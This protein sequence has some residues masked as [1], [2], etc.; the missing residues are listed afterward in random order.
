MASINALVQHFLQTHR[1]RDRDRERYEQLSRTPE[2]RQKGDEAL[3]SCATPFPA[4]N[5]PGLQTPPP[6]FAKNGRFGGY[7]S[8]TWSDHLRDAELWLV[9]AMEGLSMGRRDVLTGNR[10]VCLDELHNHVVCG[11]AVLAPGG[12]GCL[13]DAECVA[14]LHRRFLLVPY[15]ED[16]LWVNVVYDRR[17]GAVSTFDG[18]ELGRQERHDRAVAALQSLMELSSL[19]S[20]PLTSHQS[21]SRNMKPGS[22]QNSGYL[23]LEGARVFLREVTGAGL[24]WED[25]TTSPVYRSLGS[26]EVADM[27]ARNAWVS[28]LLEQ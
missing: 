9:A 5:D 19:P 1:D 21:E 23:A 11:R 20:I 10:F 26:D 7:G 27:D 4:A 2:S 22:K 18:V 16:G 28:M 17:S 13:A 8:T 14:L 25:W 6:A 15:A 3:P 12:R 24:D